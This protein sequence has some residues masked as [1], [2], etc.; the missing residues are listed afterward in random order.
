V[1]NNGQSP[2]PVLSVFDVLG[3]L[4]CFIVDADS[5]GVDTTEG[6]TLINTAA[7]NGGTC[8]ATFVD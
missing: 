2:Q 8:V 5:G 6:F 1:D 7:N 3:E 4:S